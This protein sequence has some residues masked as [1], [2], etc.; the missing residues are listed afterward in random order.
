MSFSLLSHLRVSMPLKICL[1]RMYNIMYLYWTLY[2]FLSVCL[3]LCLS[4]SPSLQLSL[5]LSVPLSVPLSFYLSLYL[6]L[7]LSVS[8][9]LSTSLILSLSQFSC[10]SLTHT[11]FLPLFTHIKAVCLFTFYNSFQICSSLH[12]LLC[13]LIYFCFALTHLLISLIKIIFFRRMGPEEDSQSVLLH[14]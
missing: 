7:Q 6:S 13:S 10:L 11:A 3:R 8:L 14:R 2:L 4:S 12:L 1:L 9:Y 5:Y